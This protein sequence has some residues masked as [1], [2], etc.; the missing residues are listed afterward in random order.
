MPKRDGTGPMRQGPMTGRGLG[1]CNNSDNEK[2]GTGRGM[3]RGLG[4]SLVNQ[5]DSSKTE[6]ELLTEQKA[7]LQNQLEA[8]DKQLENL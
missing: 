4:R 7:I 6:K 3:G 1:K 8:V 5:K 2:F